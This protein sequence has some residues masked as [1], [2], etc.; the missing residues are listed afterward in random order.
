MQAHAFLDAG[1]MSF[2]V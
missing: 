2:I 1:C